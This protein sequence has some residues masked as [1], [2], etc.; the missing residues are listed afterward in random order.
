MRF[1]GKPYNNNKST[2]ADFWNRKFVYYA[3]LAYSYARFSATLNTLRSRRHDSR[4][5]K[6]I[7][8]IHFQAV[9]AAVHSRAEQSSSVIL[10]LSW[11]ASISRHRRHMP[12]NDTLQPSA[13]SNWSHCRNEDKTHIL[14][15]AY[16]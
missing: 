5:F 13:Y 11:T 4:H 10:V 9:D 2:T 8:S 12:I 1:L 16:S 7:L 3:K 15:L 14:R 6:I